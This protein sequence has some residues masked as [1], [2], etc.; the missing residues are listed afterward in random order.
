MN[1]FFDS[2]CLIEYSRSNGS[3]IIKTLP[4]NLDLKE[5]LPILLSCCFPEKLIQ[6]SIHSF[7]LTYHICFSWSFLFNDTYY[8]IVILSKH[9]FA[10]LFCQFL[11]NVE[12]NYLKLD[13][14]ISFLKIFELLNSWKISKLNEL[15]LNYPDHQFTTPL[16]SSHSFYFQFE[17]TIF[18]NKNAPFDEIWNCLLTNKGI[19]IVGES[20]EI[21]SKTIFSL[22]SIIA[23]LKYSEPIL[24]YTRLGDPR[25]AEIINGNLKWKIVGTTNKLVIERCK[26]FKLILNIETKSSYPL[27][28]IRIN[29]QKRTSKILKNFEIFMNRNLE[30]DPYSELIGNNLNE[31]QLLEIYP[32]SNSKKLSPKRLTIDELKKFQNSLSFLDWK[33]HNLSRRQFRETFLSFNPNDILLNRSFNDL[34]KWK[35]R[36]C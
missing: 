36:S 4:K 32:Q 17:P 25:F 26:Q 27:P 18:L 21:V 15:L 14:L 31:K 9:C 2:C 12:K 6:S 23:P 3:K 28:E 33:K 35:S 1:Q 30:I 22:L 13:P 7:S 8:S 34:K 16:D 10:Y 5:D 11:K 29:L 24:V 19:L 20:A